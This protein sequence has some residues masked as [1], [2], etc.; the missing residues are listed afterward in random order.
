MGQTQVHGSSR[1]DVS[2]LICWSTTGDGQQVALSSGRASSGEKLIT[3]RVVCVFG[4]DHVGWWVNVW[5]LFPSL[6]QY[7]NWNSIRNSNLHFIPIRMCC[8]NIVQCHD[9]I[10]NY[11][12]PMR[13]GKLRVGTLKNINWSGG[14]CTAF[15][16]RI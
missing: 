8:N 2:D 13:R 6:Q 3:R 11:K 1:C 14:R 15:R 5:T 7:F 16:Y 9:V 10:K 4:S 12:R